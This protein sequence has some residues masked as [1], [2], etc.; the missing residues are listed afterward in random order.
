[1]KNN[2]LIRFALLNILFYSPSVF[3]QEIK[4]S[5][6]KTASDTV[7]LTSLKHW[8]QPIKQYP[9]VYPARAQQ[10]NVE[11][12]VMLKVLIGKDGRPKN[13]KMVNVKLS[14]MDGAPNVK[15]GSKPPVKYASLFDQPSID[16]VRKWRFTQPM[17]ADSTTALVWINVPLKYQLQLPKK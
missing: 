17:R 9:P 4:Q 5:Q 7:E 15:P 11:A 6:S 1:M 14:Y 8:P 3:G 13:L 2:I 12:E 16:A 10:E